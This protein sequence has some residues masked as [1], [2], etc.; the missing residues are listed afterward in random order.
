MNIRQV[1]YLLGSQAGKEMGWLLGTGPV[2]MEMTFSNRFMLVLWKSLE[3]I[4]YKC[5][6]F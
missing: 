3:C 6:A 5:R 1:L 2:I 4:I